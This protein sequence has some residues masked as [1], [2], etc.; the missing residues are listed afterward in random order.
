SLVFGGFSADALR[1][2]VEDTR[3]KLLVTSDGQFRRGRAVPVKEAA[4]HAVAGLDH[5]EHV[6]VVERTGDDIPWTEGRDV[7]WADALAQASPHHEPQPFDAEHPLFLIY[8]SGTTGRPKGLLH[9]TGGYLT[10]TAYTHALLFDL[11][12]EETDAVNDPQKV[13]D[14]V[15]WC[16]ADL[17]WVTAHTYEIYGPLLNGVTQVIFE[18]TPQQPHPGRHFEI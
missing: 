6:L 14:T 5:V 10:Q 4:D 13:A 17:A 12:A 11:V 3:A 9:T 8:T 2:R 1:F 16:T 15:H 18:G 7:R